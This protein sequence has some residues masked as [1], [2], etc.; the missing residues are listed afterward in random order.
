MIHLLWF[1]LMLAQSNSGSRSG[2]KPFLSTS[3]CRKNIRA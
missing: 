1:V 3:N 2:G